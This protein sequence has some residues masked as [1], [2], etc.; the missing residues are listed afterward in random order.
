MP[1][2]RHHRSSRRVPPLK[3]SDFDH[4]IH[5][6]DKDEEEAPLR[7]P[8]AGPSSHRGATTSNGAGSRAVD[9]EGGPGGEVSGLE[10]TGQPS[11]MVEGEWTPSAMPLETG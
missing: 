9:G 8:S 10:E 6:V 3:D 11:V 2:T 5:L 1:K 4:E 7:P